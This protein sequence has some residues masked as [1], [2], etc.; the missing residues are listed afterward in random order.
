MDGNNIGPS[1]IISLGKHSGGNL[2]TADQGI[3]ECHD[4]WK[5]FDGNTEHYTTPF[6]GERISFIADTCTAAAT[7]SNDYFGR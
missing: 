7:A 2:W 5:L 4:Q 1:Y 3:I 6:K